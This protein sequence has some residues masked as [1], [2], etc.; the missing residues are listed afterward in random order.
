[1]TYAVFTGAINSGYR[2][3]TPQAWLN[4]TV[5]FGIFLS[6]FVMHQLLFWA[7][8]DPVTAFN[9]GKQAVYYFEQTQNGLSV[10]VGVVNEIYEILI[11]LWNGLSN[12][13]ERELRLPRPRFPGRPSA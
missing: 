9:S 8:F 2:V 11:P 7:T 3:F 13:G 12:Y 6:L 10:F 1:M 5:T 4:V